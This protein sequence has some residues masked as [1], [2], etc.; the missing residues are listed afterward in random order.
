[1][2]L[3]ELMGVF[4]VAADT[5]MG[6]PLDHG[7]RS[8]TIAVRLSEVAGLP[9]QARSDAY[10]LALLRYIGC[11][12]DSDIAANVMGDEIAMRGRMYGADWTVPTDFI[13]RIARALG[14]TESL[15]GTMRLL[16]VLSK[17]PKMMNSSRSHCEVGDRIAAEIG[18]DEGFRKALY[19][20]FESWDGRGV[21]SKLKGDAVAL[22]MRITHVAEVFEVGHREGGVEMAREVL[23]KRAGGALD[24]Q[25]AE[26]ALSKADEL[27]ALL[28]LP[29][30]WDTAMNAEPEPRRTASE[31]QVDAILCAL[32]DFADLK[33]NFTRGHSRAVAGLVRSAA[34]SLRLAPEAVDLTI[35]AAHV[36]DLGRVAV[37]EAVWDKPGALSDSEWEQVRS[38]SYVG[39]RILSRCGPLAQVIDVSTAAHE[40]VDGSGYH[41]RLRGA[42]CAM[43]ARLLAAADVFHA[44]TE[45]RP[46]RPAKTLDEATKVLRDMTQAGALCPDAVAAVLAA[47]GQADR[48]TPK[49]SSG[50]TERELEVLRLVA[51]GKTNKEVAVALDI[52]TKTA[53]RHL[54]NIFQKIAVTT[55]AGA[56]MWAMQKGIV[57]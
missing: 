12:S 46:H 51:R 38:H 20:A 49:H 56:T 40:R 4:S 27:T 39:E 29:S 31:P 54:E 44:L 55:R 11:T 57:V 17:L 35:R 36:H 8:A 21:P 24:P 43:P 7:L 18:F 26:R 19:H 13:R 10:Y 2:R 3:A 5:G 14:A 42:G 45:E 50:L 53:G 48:P 52:S 15:G 22:P 9:A 6:M 23:A 25:L 37:S 16:R 47:R 41:R 32:G 28:E 30:A 34:E 33:S 1:M